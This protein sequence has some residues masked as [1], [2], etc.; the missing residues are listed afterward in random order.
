MI[1]K[2]QP[3]DFIVNEKIELK[4]EKGPYTYLKITKINRNTLDIVKFLENKFR[5]KVGFAGTKDKKAV[6]S[7]VL[8]LKN[9]QPEQLKH[10]K[11]DQT[12][13]EVLGTGKTPIS[14]G[15]HKGNEFIIMVKEIEK[16]AQ[17][18]TQ[19]ENY[20]DEQR[21]STHNVSIGR[22]LIKKELEKAC[23][24]I[25]DKKMNEY[26]QKRPKDFIGAL[27]TLHKKQLQFY[28]HAYQ[29]YLFNEALKSYVQQQTENTVEVPYSQGVFSFTK[30]QIKETEL[31]LATFDMAECTYYNDIFKKE[32][33]T[34]RDFATRHLPQLIST[35]TTRP[36]HVE[37]ENLKIDYKKGQAKCAFFLKKGSYATIVI[38]K[39]FA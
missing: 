22:A 31:P 25:Q 7:Q 10:L 21:F 2:E 37:V 29:S 18:Y 13:L 35:T 8:S 19:V 17:E 4:I 39:L 24:L 38:K 3:E 20:F 12:T 23:K 33:L 6:T 30:K 27:Q 5:T 36:T 11:I 34:Q 14:L 32:E 9:V 28:L 1:I 15:D 16:K 26:L